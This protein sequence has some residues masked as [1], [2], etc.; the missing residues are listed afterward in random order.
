MK[1]QSRVIKRKTCETS[2]IFYSHKPEGFTLQHLK[3]SN[4]NLMF[5]TSFHT[6][7]KQHRA[8]ESVFANSNISLCETRTNILVTSARG[9]HSQLSS[10]THHT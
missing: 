1:P 3:M 10:N 5:K 7:I 4:S 6:E 8:A 9:T 2:D